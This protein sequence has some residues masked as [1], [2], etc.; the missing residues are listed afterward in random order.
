LPGEVRK[1]TEEQKIELT[2]GV[3]ALVNELA[4][5]TFVFRMAWPDRLRTKSARTRAFNAAAEVDRVVRQY[6]E[7][8]R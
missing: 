4:K 3:S 1:V 5:P 7:A 8:T 2:N 6:V